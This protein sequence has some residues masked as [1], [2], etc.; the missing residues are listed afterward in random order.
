MRTFLFE[1]LSSFLPPNRTYYGSCY[2]INCIYCDLIYHSSSN[3]SCLC[4]FYLLD[5]VILSYCHIVIL[6]I[7]IGNKLLKDGCS[8]CFLSRRITIQ[9]V[10]LTKS[11]NQNK[12]VDA[13]RIFGYDILNILLGGLNLPSIINKWHKRY[14]NLQ[15]CCCKTCE[16]ISQWRFKYKMNFFG[17]CPVSL[18][19]CIVVGSAKKKTYPPPKKDTH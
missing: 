13:G 7:V 9:Y 16:G 6:D 14:S 11:Q 18:Y 2:I 10:L 4:S 3:M 5:I 1:K 12:F 17:D 15:L 8:P 19:E